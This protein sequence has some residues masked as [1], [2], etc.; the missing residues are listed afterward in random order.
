MMYLDFYGLDTTPFALTP[1][2]SFFFA[3]RP[4]TRP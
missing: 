2:T 1:D 3:I 4:T